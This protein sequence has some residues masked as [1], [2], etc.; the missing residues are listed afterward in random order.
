M[1][2]MGHMSLTRDPN[3]P[4][5]PTSAQRRQIQADVEVIVTKKQADVSTKAIRDRYGSLAAAKR[6]APEDLT[7]QTEFNE[8]TRLRK[9]HDSLFK[10]KLT[11]LFETSREEYFSNLGAA[12]LENQH[13]GQEQPAGPS[14][15]AFLFSEREALA[16]LL[17]PS[18]TLKRKSHQEQIQDSC[19]IIN[20]TPL[21]VAAVS[22]QG[23]GAGHD[24]IIK[25]SPR[26]RETSQTLSPASSIPSPISIPCSVLG[27]SV[28]SAWGML[29]WR[30]ISERGASRTL[31]HL[32][33]TC[34][35]NIFST[36]LLGSRSTVPTLRA[37]WTGLFFRMPTTTRTM[38]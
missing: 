1:K 29:V 32:P 27:P 28:C 19:H 13:T 21:C 34:T 26:S 16:K 11:S 6:K 10:R 37:L 25:T 9:D 14:I 31:S 20:S 3:A 15:P 17:F 38:L 5:E 22:I 4:A 7:V 30:R 23:R 18:P 33:D 24:A 35:S 36:F 2:L 12:C 8:N